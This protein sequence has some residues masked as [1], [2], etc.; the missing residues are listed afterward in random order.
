MGGHLIGRG[1]GG[2][3]NFGGVGSCHL[4]PPKC[5]V[6]READCRVSRC[7]YSVSCDHC[8]ETGQE[9]QYIGTTGCTLH[10]R[11]RE[12]MC[13][14]QRRST[15]NAQSK[16][17][18][19]KHPTQEPKYT[20]RI[21]SGGIKYNIERYIKEALQIESAKENTNIN[22][23]NQKSEWGMTGVPRLRVHW[24]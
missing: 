23:I 15:S 12:H 4:G 14:V 6:D 3:D 16:H 7:V 24:D 5:N 22:L 17:H 20:T 1:M 8:T 13:E 9:T 2:S 11:Q 21:I 18:W 10:K 19:E